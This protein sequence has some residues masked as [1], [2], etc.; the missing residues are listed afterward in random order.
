MLSS[1]QKLPFD[2]LYHL[3]T[4]PRPTR[5]TS[6]RLPRASHYQSPEAGHD[7]IVKI[8]W[9]VIALSAYVH[10][11][12]ERWLKKISLVGTALHYCVAFVFSKWTILWRGESMLS[13]V[14][15]LGWW[16]VKDRS[17]RASLGWCFTDLSAQRQIDLVSKSH[18][19]V[20][21][22]CTDWSTFC[23]VEWR[24]RTLGTEDRTWMNELLHY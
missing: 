4:Y 19:G 18:L 6:R 1:R 2:S 9:L 23:K 12:R 11:S 16:K 7:V 8:W 22:L 5:F 14:E 10:L 17:H 13:E 21:S 24:L 20:R 3:L 15:F